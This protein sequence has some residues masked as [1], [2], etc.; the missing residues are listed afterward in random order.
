[1]EREFLEQLRLDDQPLP[2]EIVEAI[3]AKCEQDARDFDARLA[4]LQ[5][6]G[7]LT[8]AIRQAGGRN[9]KAVQALLDMDAL[10][11]SNDPKATEKAIT[12]LKKENGW[13][14]AEAAVPPYAPGT[15]AMQTG[16]VQ[17]PQTLAGA[18][19][20]RAANRRG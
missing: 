1:M 2:G 10:R 3:W 9:A 6:E 7:A 4:Q 18:L 19:R 11:T 8:E 15:G 20:E 16:I 13:L 12:Q 14:F 5:F 17:E